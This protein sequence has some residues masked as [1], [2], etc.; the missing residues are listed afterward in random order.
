MTE[1]VGDMGGGGLRPSARAPGYQGLH[2]NQHPGR[3]VL[4]KQS[5]PSFWC[6]KELVKPNKSCDLDLAVANDLPQKVY[7]GEA[8]GG[9]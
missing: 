1:M 8:W 9:W 6:G 7:N 3:S 2:Q 5:H 4:Q